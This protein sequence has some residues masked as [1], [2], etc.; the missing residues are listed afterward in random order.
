MKPLKLDQFMDYRFLSQLRYAP[1]GQQAAFVVSRCD[2]ENNR[3]ESN[4]YLYRKGN[5]R[6]LSGL[7][8]ESAFFWED[9]NHVLFPACRS[10]D[11]K[12]RAEAGETFTAYYRL[13]TDGGE[14]EKAFELPL[15]AGELHPMEDGRWYFTAEIDLCCPDAHLLSKEEREKKLA[16]EKK[17]ADY[18]VLEEHP[19]WF[20]GGAHRNHR[21]TALFVYDSKS[22]SVHRLTPPDMDVS[23]AEYCGGRLY[24]LG[25]SYR[26]RPG[27]RPGFF[28]VCPEGG[29]ICCI[30][31]QNTRYFS[32]LMRRGDGLLLGISEGKTYAYEE[33]PFLYHYAVEDG[34]LTQICENYGSLY[35]SVG[36][37]CRLGG[38]AG[39]RCRGKDIYTL[40]TREGACHLYRI[41]GEGH[42]HPVYNGTGS[43]DTFDVNEDGEVLVIAMLDGKLQELYRLEQD[44]K[45]TCLSDFNEGTLQDC[46]VAEYEPLRIQS[47]GQQIT[48]WILKPWDYDPEKS[49]PA[50]LD[51]HGG[52]RTAYGQ[53]F[54]HE[55]QYWAGQGYFVFFCN[56]IGSDGRGDAFADIRG[57]YG[58]SEYRN[59][60][61]FTDAVLERYPQIDQTRVAVTGGSYGGFMTNWIIGHTDRFCCAA[62][63][64]SISNW[65][66]FYGTSDIGILFGEYQTD[67]TI[68]QNPEKMW[69]QSPLK[70]AGNFKTPTLIIHSDCD[71]R[72]PIS[73]G[74]QLFTALKEM[75]VDSRMVVFKGENH[76][77]SRSGKP[78]HRLRRLQEISDWFAKYTK[79]PGSEAD[80]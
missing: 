28:S 46:Y 6:R 56:P 1:G 3:Y 18:I 21:R 45:Y 41:D 44:G 52:P 49:Y 31:P 17:D 9:A 78:L 38:G 5:I 4:L 77:L 80:A 69:Q 34:T 72:C 64:R 57:Q 10:E 62:T 2:R 58:Q 8:K 75:G 60:M 42:W 51:I 19:F 29:E 33:S 70:Y 76:E 61:D 15:S 35:N 40:S 7:G 12:K 47:E 79:N 66:S 27:Y 37:D 71:F 53:V 73:E 11:E 20:N 74:Y 54:Y 63:Q 30:Y 32:G 14:A 22:G 26:G 67:A 65:V 23:E 43:V 16:E 68:F 24:F 55:M 36:S 13:A 48:G 39:L 50:I 25:E 59:L